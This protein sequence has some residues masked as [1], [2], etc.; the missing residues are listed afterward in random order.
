MADH[1]ALEVAQTVDLHVPHDWSLRSQF[2]A[3]CS[4]AAILSGFSRNTISVVLG[5]GGFTT[6]IPKRAYPTCVHI[7]GGTVSAYQWNYYFQQGRRYR[8]LRSYR[9]GE[10]CELDHEY[11]KKVI[12]F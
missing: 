1:E 9:N 2:E 7:F 3:Q 6:A 10:I 4:R 5:R 12:D 8:V 11:L